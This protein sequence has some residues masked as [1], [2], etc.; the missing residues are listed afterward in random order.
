MET[1]VLNMYFFLIQ[2]MF[3]HFFF[4]HQVPN[5]KRF[6]VNYLCRSGQ[7]QP[8][9][10]CECFRRWNKCLEPWVKVAPIKTK[11]CLYNNSVCT[12]NVCTI[13]RTGE[14]WPLPWTML[15]ISFSIWLSPKIA[16]ILLK[17]PIFI[18]YEIFRRIN[19]GWTNF[20][21]C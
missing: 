18:A 14:F 6:R 12:I 17:F 19:S 13:K 21:A 1:I 3:Q 7:A 15:T 10:V 16:R 20:I 9:L 5:T 8:P 4:L 11:I 2:Q